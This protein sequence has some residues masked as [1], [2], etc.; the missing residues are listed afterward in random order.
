MRDKC[1]AVLRDA[2]RKTEEEKAHRE[3]PNRYPEYGGEEMEKRLT[4]GRLLGTMFSNQRA[5]KTNPKTAEGILSFRGEEVFRRI[6]GK[7]GR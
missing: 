7:R 1:R 6:P 4:P 5:G 3:D 2:V